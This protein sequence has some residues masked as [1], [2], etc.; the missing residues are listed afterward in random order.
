MRLLQELPIGQATRVAPTI[1]ADPATNSVPSRIVVALICRIHLAAVV[2]RA[3]ARFRDQTKAVV[4]ITSV[5][6]ENAVSTKKMEA[7]SLKTLLLVWL[8]YISSR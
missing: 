3:D 8:D 7:L 6:T 4:C 2:S 5:G 1:N